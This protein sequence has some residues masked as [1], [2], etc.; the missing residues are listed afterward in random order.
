M[1]K[2]LAFC[3]IVAVLCP[4]CAKK[5][6]AKEET[7]P[8][9]ASPLENHLVSVQDGLAKKDYPR[10]LRSSLEAFFGETPLLIN[11]P[12]FVTS[13]NNTF[14][15]YTPKQGDEFA[16]GDVIHLY[17]EPVGFT[18]RKNAEGQY[19]FG[20][21]AD[22]SLE[23][24]SGK[25]L[26]GQKD[27]ADLNFKSWNFNTEVALTFTYTFSGLGKGKYKIVTLVKDANSEK[28]ASVEKTISMI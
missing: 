27:F 3:V 23:D 15:V 18:V 24:E 14:G 26:G 21:K 1:K 12:R 20:F 19:E 9:P 4:A 25:V 17:C 28:N 10:A 7:A 16:E 22:F 8:P 5:E 6:Q 13:E 11:S 2:L